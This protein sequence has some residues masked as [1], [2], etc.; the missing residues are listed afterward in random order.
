MRRAL[1]VVLD[2]D[3]GRKE[4]FCGTAHSDP[5]YKVV[6]KLTIPKNGWNYGCSGTLIGPNTILTAAHCVHDGPGGGFTWPSGVR[7]GACEGRQGTNYAPYKI[8]AMT[9]Y[10]T[11][12]D[13]DY[14][15]ALI[16]VR[17][18]PGAAQ[19]YSGFGYASA[20]S[21]I[22]DRVRVAGYPCD[23]TWYDLWGMAGEAD[24]VGNQI[25]Y[26]LDTYGCQSGSGQ[27][28]TSWQSRSS[29]GELS[30]RV[31]GVHAYGR[32]GVGKNYGPKLRSEVFWIINMHARGG[33]SGRVPTY[34]GCGSE[35]DHQHSQ[36]VQR[37]RIQLHGLREPRLVLRPR[38]LPRTG[39]DARRNLQTPRE[40]LRCL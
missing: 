5:N 38:C 32:E 8:I 10:L 25:E 40:Q 22:Y 34:C 27:Q 19:G 16:Q 33:G 21:S 29:Q 2:P 30:N 3:D 17:G 7:F 20:A 35:V 23:K 6:A 18:N 12:R 11:H 1:A 9:R 14:D 37:A 4:V 15:L 28:S 13:V 36:L 39:M 31:V 26:W 24:V